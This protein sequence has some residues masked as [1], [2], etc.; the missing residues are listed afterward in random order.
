MAW[1]LKSAW[2]HFCNDFCIYVKKWNGQV[3][4]TIMGMFI[5]LK[6]MCNGCLCKG[7]G[8]AALHQQLLKQSLE[9]WRKLILTF[10]LKLCYKTIRPWGLA[11]L[12]RC[13]LQHG[14]LVVLSSDLVLLFYLGRLWLFNVSVNTWMTFFYW[15]YAFKE[16]SNIT[17]VV[18][19]CWMFFLT[20]CCS[21]V[22][23]PV[24]VQHIR[25]RVVRG[26]CTP[27]CQSSS[28]SGRLLTGVLF[29]GVIA[30]Y[31]PV[32]KEMKRSVAVLSLVGSVAPNHNQSGHGF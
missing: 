20:A 7:R 17:P 32:A 28:A 31:S 29:G 5:L 8:K 9:N 26:S 21:C 2:Q 22:C 27:M 19:T 24:W 30:G 3:R 4:S 25:Q 23:V 11:T 14:S 6:Q 13:K 1:F 10:F 12:H 15:S 18:L 16:H